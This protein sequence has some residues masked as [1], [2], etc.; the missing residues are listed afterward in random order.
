VLRQ[1]FYSFDPLFTEN[2][3]KPDT[4]ERGAEKVTG[5]R[6]NVKRFYH[7]LDQNSYNVRLTCNSLIMTTTHINKF[8]QK[9]GPSLPTQKFPLPTRFL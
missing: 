4:I 5:L 6:L 2:F 9:V 3:S 8:T 1:G 7:D